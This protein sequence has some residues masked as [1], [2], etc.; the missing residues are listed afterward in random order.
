[1]EADER[2]AA[3]R[4]GSDRRDRPSV[5]PASDK[6]PGATSDPSSAAQRFRKRPVVI[7][8][9]E[10]TGSNWN[11]L[12][13]FFGSKSGEG[14]WQAAGRLIYIYTLEGK[15]IADKHDWIVRGVQGEFYPVKPDIF[16]ETYEPA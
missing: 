15:M 5:P 1:M 7:E 11:E 16:E 14:K 4:L 10:F 6:S 2:I 12:T 3:S 8:A 13:A 9:V